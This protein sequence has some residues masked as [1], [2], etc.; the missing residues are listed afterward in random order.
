M[1]ELTQLIA[2][3]KMKPQYDIAVHN[4][5][6]I[7]N[8]EFVAQVHSLSE[9]IAA[10]PHQH[11]AL[12][13]QDSYLFCVALFAVLLCERE[14][15]LLTNNLPTTITNFSHTLDALLTD[16]PSLPSTPL[17]DRKKVCLD[18]PL[19]PQLYI[20]MF[21]SGSTGT[22]KKVRRNLRQFMAEI[23]VLESLFH[24][25]V[26]GTSVYASVSHQHAYGLLFYIL[27][28]LCAMRKI[29]MP[30]L[31]FP[32]MIQATLVRES[33]V[34]L[35]TSP[36]LLK[37]MPEEQI[38]AKK[39][40]VFSAGGLLQTDTA[41]LIEKTLQVY[42]H[43]ILGCTETGAV[44]WR[45][46]LHHSNWHALPQV[47]LSLD[48]ESPCLKVISNFFEHEN[49]FVMGD[50]VTFHP[51]GTFELHGRLDRIE[52]IEGNRVCLSE[53]EALLKQH[54]WVT[55]AYLLAMKNGREYLVAIIA[56][57]QQGLNCLKNRKKSFFNAEFSAILSTSFGHVLTPKKFRYVSH[58][59]VNA[60]GKYVSS[61]LR[62]LFE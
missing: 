55:D 23:R 42:P 29:V 60:Q 4:Q 7:S 51:D 43:E 49:G 8:L 58:I 37:R 15:I 34:T 61:E 1:I 20:S 6:T 36:A 44:A 24:E 2:A 40:V 9:K 16:I 47:S 27:W 41:K 22:P 48:N 57:S 25:Q 3:L 11:W 30:G 32:E 5:R 33:G 10:T 52:K 53:M 14:P 46:Q 13:Y 12:C 28:P 19:N 45:Q 54:H 18:T 56:L 17:T 50:R 26:Q 38:A 62:E 35:I 31:L 59:P 21:T 39:R